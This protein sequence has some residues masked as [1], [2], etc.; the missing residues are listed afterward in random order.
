VAQHLE[1]VT[2]VRATTVMVET[3]ATRAE[4]RSWE[5]TNLLALA[6]GEADEVS[7]KVT[8]LDGELAIA[9]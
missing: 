3:C 4:R 8:H 1:E 7:Q 6:H 2:Q 9:R 5:S